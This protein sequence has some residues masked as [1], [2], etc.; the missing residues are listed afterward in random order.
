MPYKQKLKICI[1]NQRNPKQEITN[2]SQSMRF[3]PIFFIMQSPW[4]FDTNKIIP[5][6]FRQIVP[7]TYQHHSYTKQSERSD[8]PTWIKI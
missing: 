4:S 7:D 3:I 6:Y 2:S 8:T 1:N 5:L